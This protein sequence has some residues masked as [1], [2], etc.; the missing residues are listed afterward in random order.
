MSK[1]PAISKTLN[2]IFNIE[3]G[4]KKDILL[5]VCFSFLGGISF[6]F[7]STATVSVFI[8]T[9]KAEMLPYA[10]IASGVV[11]FILWYLFARIQ[12]YLSFGRL[13]SYGYLFLLVSIAFLFLM[14]QRSGNDWWYF[15]MFVWMRFFTFLN[16]VMFGGIF[17]RIFNLQQG[18]R[19]FALISAGDVVSQMLGYFSV[20]LLLRNAGIPALL[21]ISM[22]GIMLQLCLIFFL[23]N[24]YREK[25]ATNQLKPGTVNATV[26]K[27][28]GN[29]KSY[30]SLM[31]LVSLL[32][33]LGFYYVDYMFL[34]ELKLEYTS[35]QAVAGFLGLFLG[36]VAI[37][38]LMTRLFIS[39]RLLT[40]YG[41]KFGINILPL[42][43]L[44][45]TLLI[46]FFALMP[47][48]AGLVFS[49]IAFS[50]LLERVL[51]FSF[52]EPAYQIFYQP[53][54]PEKRFSLRT[55]MEGVP[56]A[57][58]VIVAGLLI[59]GFNLL[60]FKASL[61]LNLLFLAVLISW[62]FITK[63][64]YRQYCMMLAQFVKQK[65]SKDS[66]I[67]ASNTS[68]KAEQEFMIR[69]ISPQEW[70][71][72]QQM[73][74]FIVNAA[75]DKSV[76]EKRYTAFLLETML[77]ASYFKEWLDKDPMIPQL[78]K[79][80]FQASDQIS[81]QIR[82][83]DLLSIVKKEEGFIKQQLLSK[84]PFISQMAAN[85]LHKQGA[86]FDDKEKAACKIWLQEMMSKQLWYFATIEDLEEDLLLEEL[87]MALDKENKA[88][89]HLVFD[90]L[91]FV[92]E[93]SAV[94]EI[95]DGVTGQQSGDSKMLAHELLENFFDQ[96]IREKITGLYLQ[97]ET[98]AR[99][100]ALQDVYP[101]Q[102]LSVGE[103][104]VDIIRKEYQLVPLW[105]KLL[106]L[107]AIALR[108]DPFKEEILLECLQ[109][110]HPLLAMSA[111]ENL[112][113]S[114]PESYQQAFDKLP[115]L[116]QKKMEA[117][118]SRWREHLKAMAN[119]SLP[120]NIPNVLLPVL[121][122]YFI[123]EEESA[124]RHSI[125]VIE[126]ENLLHVPDSEMLYVNRTQKLYVP[127]SSSD[128]FT[129]QSMAGFMSNPAL[130][131]FN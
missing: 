93:P 56:K 131:F 36:G 45:S 83:L 29:M 123:R 92:Y 7:Y 79:V 37:V 105:L 90:V 58:G 59:L 101:Q 94:A 61:Y 8:S 34:N 5:L 60:G 12:Q 118:P 97:E 3:K 27:Q 46:V 15:S 40:M 130:S 120:L 75:S 86:V 88:F 70:E 41:L 91:A 55:R 121:A 117:L 125:F 33:M 128:I 80:Q 113:V 73:N 21:W 51:R 89:A 30:Y 115:L 109:S 67:T 17:A 99:L 38:E 74:E 47:G 1:V 6:V 11:G 76:N 69:Y 106:A 98:S 22:G 25:F 78:L 96:E 35:G 39:G 32:P 81:E 116:Q 24:H 13:L 63:A 77:P 18:K 102:Q 52:N 14:A 57:L 112:K 50:K 103:R 122:A 2:R 65:F 53:V 100:Q 107:E 4:E 23:N 48:F 119:H 43:L 10:F 9:F 31:F 114:Y 72:Y 95:R 110:I 19:L 49:M 82:I 126:P 26:Q 66:N 44:F 54:P 64:S 87:R 124:G 85:C 108:N 16:A 84:N 28:E 20:P 62:L 42:T 129:T 111:A 71:Q 127:R 68:V 104:L